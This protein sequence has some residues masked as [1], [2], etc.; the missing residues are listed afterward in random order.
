MGFYV[1]GLIIGI[2][3]FIKLEV[4]NG[5]LMFYNYV[6]NDFINLSG[7]FNLIGNVEGDIK[8]GGIV[9]YFKGVVL[10]IVFFFN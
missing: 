5:G 9:F 10:N 8:L 2:F 7:R 4:Y 6:S 1:D 3:N